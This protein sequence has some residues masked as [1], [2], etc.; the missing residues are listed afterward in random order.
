VITSGFVLQ[1][2]NK[3]RFGV[4]DSM[5][6]SHEKSIFLGKYATSS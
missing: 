3:F 4:S 5:S 1:N 6:L 2:L